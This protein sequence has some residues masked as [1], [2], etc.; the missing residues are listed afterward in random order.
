MT[1]I[2]FGSDKFAY[3]HLQA[4]WETGYGIA[5]CVTKADRPVGRGMKV[6]HSPIKEFALKVNI[7]LWQPEDLKDAAFQEK[8]RKTQ[9]DLFVVIA[10]GKLLP[11]EVLK[12]PRIAAI[13]VHASLL[14][15]YR[16]A[17]PINWAIINGEKVTGISIIKMGPKMDEGDIIVREKIDIDPEDTAI[18]LKEKMSHLGAKI[19]QRAIDSLDKNDYT[20]LSQDSRLASWAPK[21]TKAMG[22]IAWDQKAADI[23]NL[24][25]GLLPWPSA[26]TYF[27]GR[28]LKLLK[29]EVIQEN[30]LNKL[31]GEIISIQK[32][33]VL[34]AA[35]EGAVLIKEVHFESSKPMPAYSFALG[36]N[37]KAGEILK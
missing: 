23:H 5:A 3:T 11:E 27:N 1:I 29:T 33:G 36:H 28:L 26:Y 25:R 10:Y 37:V 19:L 21:L 4:L 8:L 32:E 13:N 30:F 35:Q 7:P 31:P 17:A 14:P 24:A 9:S 6:T 16:G 20:L 2:F 34:V 22:Q 12:I 15:Q 18:T